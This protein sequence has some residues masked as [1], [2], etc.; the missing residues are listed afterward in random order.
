[1]QP[2]LLRQAIGYF[3]FQTVSHHFC[4]ASALAILRKLLAPAGGVDDKTRRNWSVVC[5][6]TEAVQFN[7]TRL[8]E[9]YISLR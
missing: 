9:F 2:I 3:G 5:H 1:M 8:P 4:G 6:N 7:C